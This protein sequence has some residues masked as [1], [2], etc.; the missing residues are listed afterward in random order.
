MAASFGRSIRRSSAAQAVEL[1][2]ADYRDRV[3]VEMI[4]GAS[5]PPIGQLT[6]L[7]T[8]PPSLPRSAKARYSVPAMRPSPGRV[9]VPSALTLIIGP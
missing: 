7:L 9:T 4:G 5:F 6:Y 2:L 1:E 3:P 8:L